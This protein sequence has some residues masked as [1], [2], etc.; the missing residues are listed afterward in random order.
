QTNLSGG[1]TLANAVILN[2]STTTVTLSGSQNLTLSG[3]VSLLGLN[4]V[5]TS[6][7]A[8][9]TLSGP[10]SGTGALTKTNANTPVLS[11]SNSQ[12]GALTVNAS[13][14]SLRITGNNASS[15][16]GV[17]LGTL[18]G[19]GTLGPLSAAANA[20]AANGTDSPGVAIG[21]QQV[22]SANFSLGGNLTIQI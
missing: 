1:V 7:P 3:P 12:T 10:I 2:G 15:P 14:G 6:N 8:L 18:T 11:G 22:P 4:T 21:N 16:V 19:N 9:S 17:I 13:G 5:S 20:G